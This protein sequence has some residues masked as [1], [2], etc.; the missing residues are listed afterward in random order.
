[1]TSADLRALL[2]NVSQI[3]RDAASYVIQGRDN[4]RNVQ[5]ELQRD[6]KV[7]ADRRL[8]NFILERLP[9]GPGFKI[10]SEESGLLQNGENNGGYWWIV[11]PLDGSLN[12]SRGIPLSCIS[13]ALWRG[14]EPVLGVVYDF[15]RDELFTGVEGSGAW[16]NDVPIRVG[17][18]KCRGN[19]VLCTGFP[20]ASDFSPDALMK[21]VK[22]IIDYKKIR[23]LGTAALSLAY[24]AAGRA[25]YYCEDNIKLWDVAAGLALVKA[26]GGNVYCSQ[27]ALSDN[28]FNVRAS[29]CFLQDENSK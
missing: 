4:L 10:L 9:G 6:V 19:A 27:S 28:I 5:C 22:S 26:A 25:D 7:E 29:N 17:E 20:V 12:Y 23:L 15:N 2:G 8:E 14:M 21:F 13:L 16:L 1:M 11:D 3:A 18:C 24:V